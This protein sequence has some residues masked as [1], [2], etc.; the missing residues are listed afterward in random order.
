MKTTTDLP[1]L[2][3]EILA[4]LCSAPLQKARE[5]G[6][7]AIGY[8]CSYVP[9]PLLAVE[10][11]TPVRM[12]APGV[13]GT[14]LADTYLSSVICTYVRSVLE[15]SMEGLYDF[16]DGWV[17]TASC[18][19][20]RRLYDNLQYLEKPQFNYII[21]LPHKLSDAALAWYIEELEMLAEALSKQYG[22]DTGRQQLE[23]AIAEHNEY[24]RLMREIGLLRK[25][26]NPPLTGEQFHRL[27]IAGSSVPKAA[28]M[29]ALQELSDSL[30]N[31]A[32][33]GPVRARL[34]LVGSQL[35][36]P[37]YIGVIESLGGLVVADRFCL[38]SKPGLDAIEVTGEPLPDL[39]AHYLR[40]TSCPRMMEEFDSRVDNI[41]QLVEE[42]RADGVILQ[43][44]KFCDTWGV[45]QSSLVDELRE[46][47]IPV[48]R[49]E[50]E[51]RLS[52][53][54]QMRTRVQAF[55]ESIG[56]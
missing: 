9:E 33:V 3:D 22:V 52:G 23:R 55:L 5:A 56:K 14:E 2:F 36:D 47:E 17:F 32:G 35:D 18:D 10:G 31:G 24:L 53:E 12:R 19:H 15:F 25:G 16:I 6:E 51:Y 42:Y 49:L 44:M 8:T 45:E 34:L 39:A 38:G 54:G 37:E 13:A 20:L 11:L 46:R 27:V 21:D 30:K 7:K 1:P 48:L 41:V 28:V 26:D 4:D 50:R 29:T 43:T 40:K